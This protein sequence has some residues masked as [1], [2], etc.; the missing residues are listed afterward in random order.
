MGLIDH[1][2]HCER[3]WGKYMKHNLTETDKYFKSSKEL[4][5]LPDEPKIRGWFK[6]ALD[7]YSPKNIYCIEVTFVGRESKIDESSHDCLRNMGCSHDNKLEGH[8]SYSCVS[9]NYLNFIAML[10]TL[11]NVTANG[12]SIK[13]TNHGLYL[14]HMI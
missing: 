7:K 2:A 1:S 4:I 8:S 11:I 9:E 10:G 3:K 6:K 12:S 13:A 14:K 5:C